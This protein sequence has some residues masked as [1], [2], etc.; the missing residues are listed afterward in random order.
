MLG[1]VAQISDAKIQISK[2]K[3]S[4]FTSNELGCDSSSHYHKQVFFSFLCHLTVCKLRKKICLNSLGEK[5]EYVRMSV[6]CCASIAG[7]KNSA[8]VSVTIMMLEMHAFPNSIH[9][10]VS[11]F[12]EAYLKVIIDWDL[13]QFKLIS[14][15][16][17]ARNANL[18]K[19]VFDDFGFA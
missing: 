8:R 13:N 16:L 4:R 14:S 2:T 1:L 17:P 9:Y 6:W 7:G 10:F 3:Y 11:F 12:E 19:K 18:K 15:H 5:H